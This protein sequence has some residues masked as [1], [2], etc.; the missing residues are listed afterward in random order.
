MIAIFKKADVA[1]IAALLALSGIL[2]FLPGISRA[3]G[4]VVAIKVDG[5]IYKRAS[6]LDD[7]EIPILSED[8]KR[9]NTVAI[10]DGHVEMLDATCPDGLCVRQGKIRGMGEIIVCLPNRVTVEILGSGQGF[11]AVVQ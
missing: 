1:L 6:L 3:E 2:A 9:A 11:D 5:V 4:G 8:G 7:A 10:R